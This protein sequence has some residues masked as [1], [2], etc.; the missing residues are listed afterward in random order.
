[1][2]EGYGG[3]E[4]ETYISNILYIDNQSFYFTEINNGDPGFKS[5]TDESEA[6]NK[7]TFTNKTI[8]STKELTWIQGDGTYYKVNH[9][10]I[11]FGDCTATKVLNLLNDTVKE[12]EFGGVKIIIADK[13]QIYW[14][15]N[16]G[17][18][19]TKTIGDEY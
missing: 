11:I 4:I 13:K 19:V 6:I 8:D 2:S 17:D 14:I 10:F 12:E 5:C 18:L 3:R 1:M 16:K 9:S 15:N 7:F